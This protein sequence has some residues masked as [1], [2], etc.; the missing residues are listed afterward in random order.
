MTAAKTPKLKTSIKHY[1]MF[2]WKTL[3]GLSAINGEENLTEDTNCRIC[4]K[5]AVRQHYELGLLANRILTQKR[6]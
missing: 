3:C 6:Q 1:S 2:A 5:E 4:L